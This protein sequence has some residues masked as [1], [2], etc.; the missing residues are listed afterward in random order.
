MTYS[1]NDLAE[2]FD[3]GVCALQDIADALNRIAAALDPAPLSAAADEGSPVSPPGDPSE[4]HE[5]TAAPTP[6][7]TAEAGSGDDPLP[8]EPNVDYVACSSKGP[9]VILGVDAPTRE[10]IAEAENATFLATEQQR[11]AISRQ[12]A[13]LSEQL[14]SEYLAFCDRN[15]IPTEPQRMTRRQAATVLRLIGERDPELVG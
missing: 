15:G 6:S 10:Q 4:A 9:D 2:M 14:T 1:I 11:V 12:V 3:T 13:C 8:A 7:G 5:G